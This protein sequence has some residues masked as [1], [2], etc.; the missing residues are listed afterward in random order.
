MSSRQVNGFGG[1]GMS[2][3]VAPAEAGEAMDGQQ[4]VPTN[5]SLE[6]VLL[7]AVP[8]TPAEGYSTGSS[9]VSS[10][11]SPSMWRASSALNL[12]P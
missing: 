9:Q 1:S 7:G 8:L 11:P 5:G 12:E 6:G 3:P 2:P 4:K 10:D